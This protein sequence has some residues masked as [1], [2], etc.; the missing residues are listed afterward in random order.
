MTLHIL[1]NFDIKEKENVD[2]YHKQL[3]AIK[4]AFADAKHYVTDP[5]FMKVTT[6]QLL[7][8]E[9]G[10]K[11]T[12]EYWLEIAQKANIIPDDIAKAGMHDCGSIRRMLIT[13]INTAKANDKNK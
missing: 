8:D 10:K 12:C 1:K 4:I 3:E 6:D 11:Q 7:S 13:S 2:T 9:Y 5:K